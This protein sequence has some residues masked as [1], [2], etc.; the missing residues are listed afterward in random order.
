MD[1]VFVAL[2]MLGA[3]YLVAWAVP[4]AWFRRKKEAAFDLAVALLLVSLFVEVLKFATQRE[5]PFLV[6]DDVHTISA[7]GL[8]QGSG[9]AFPS[10]HAARAFALAASL[11]PIARRPV[12]ITLLSIAA[13]VGLSRIYLGLHWPSDVIGGATLGIVIALLVRSAGSRWVGYARARRSLIDSISRRAL[14]AKT[15]D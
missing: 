1:Y 2:T 4:V 15:P 14:S 9:F 6:L 11:A 12:A 3:S 5:R 10:G 7:Y 13:L 8:A